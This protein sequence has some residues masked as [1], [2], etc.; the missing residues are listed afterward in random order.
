[1]AEDK[2][3]APPA[4]EVAAGEGGGGEV[5][6]HGGGKVRAPTTETVARREQARPCSPDA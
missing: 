4:E 5:L 1:M 2:P 6:G 3:L